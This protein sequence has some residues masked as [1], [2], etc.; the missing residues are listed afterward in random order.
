M[1]V[2]KTVTLTYLSRRKQD[3][4]RL[5][6]YISPS[7]AIPTF[8]FVFCTLQSRFLFR[9]I[10]DFVACPVAWHTYVSSAASVTWRWLWTKLHC[11][12]AFA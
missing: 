3:F 11:G 10:W 12:N 2:I 7:L 4:K 8:T 9:S 6:W 1:L 5:F